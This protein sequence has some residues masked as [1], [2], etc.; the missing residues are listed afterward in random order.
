MGADVGRYVSAVGPWGSVAFLL[1][2]ALAVFGAVA[3]LY[4]VSKNRIPEG[5]VQIRILG[6]LV[7]WGQQPSEETSSKNLS[8]SSPKRIETGR[9]AH[10][11]HR[12]KPDK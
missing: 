9:E 8:N 6:I 2:S 4:A 11:L 10:M 3:I 7:R 12:I 1:V 5:E